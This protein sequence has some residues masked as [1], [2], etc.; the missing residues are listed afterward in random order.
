MIATYLAAL[1]LLTVIGVGARAWLGPQGRPRSDVLPLGAAVAIVLAYPLARVLDLRAIAWLLLVAGLVA[2]VLAVWRSRGPDGPVGRPETLEIVVLAGGVVV[3]LL[4]LI[5]AIAVG[6]P[7]AVAHSTRDGFSY[8]ATIGWLL[9]NGLTRLPEGGPDQALY[10]ITRAQLDDGFGIGFEMLGAMGAA[11]LGRE[12]YQVVN[13]VSAIGFP[14]AAAGWLALARRVGTPVPAAIPLVLLAAAAPAFLLPYS[15]NQGPHFL[16]LALLPFSLACTID[17]ARDP[18]LR[19]LVIAAIAWGATLGVYTAL[20]PWLV[21]CTAAAI[22]AVYRPPERGVA[23]ARRMAMHAGAALL[24]IIVVTP[25]VHLQALEFIRTIGRPD[26]GVTSARWSLDDYA[27]VLTGGAERVP[28]ATEPPLDWSTAIATLLVL[29]C[30]VAALVLARRGTL[31]AI[32]AAGV[33]TTLLVGAS[34]L[35]NGE[36]TAG[37]N[38]FKASITG[39]AILAGCAIA[40][41]VV[42]PRARRGVA[43][44]LAGVLAAA[45]LPVAAG[46]LQSSYDEESGFRREEIALGRAIRD[47]PPDS[48]VLVEGTTIPTRWEYEMRHVTAYFGER[49]GVEDV[50]GLGSIA[51]YLTVRQDPP[52]TRPWRPDTPWDYV[53]TSGA[54]LRQGARQVVWSS[55]HYRIERAPVLDVTNYGPGWYGPET[56]PDGRVHAWTAGDAALVVSNRGV[57]PRVATL[58]FDVQSYEVPRRVEVTAQGARARVI[59]VPGRRVRVR[60]PVPVPADST[61]VVRLFSPGPPRPAPP[62]DGRLLA[63]DVSGLRIEPSPA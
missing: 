5:P 25:F 60:V 63:F 16:A 42:A 52:G 17:V 55:P 54:Q 61:R 13:A 44:A 49:D 46:L 4:A 39:G 62:G 18:R 2:I 6:F 12:S 19:P 45:W 38:L 40:A 56:D 41:L 57:R 9:D 24:A 36:A 27:A 20:L 1:V 50:E 22:A 35:R 14:L 51:S 11:L 30:A 37:Y 47:L 8:M 3:G 10:G 28:F 48:T 23:L 33:G 26:S 7:T 59:A 34:L 29:G 43:P 58:A 15:M 32:A 53:V 31:V 21:V